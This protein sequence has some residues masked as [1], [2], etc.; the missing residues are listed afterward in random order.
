MRYALLACMLQ[1]CAFYVSHAFLFV[2]LR[3]H[4]L[5][6]CVGFVTHMISNNPPGIQRSFAV[7]CDVFAVMSN[8]LTMHS[9]KERSE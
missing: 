6:S 1:V 4:V 8:S 7:S 2:M 5:V 9:K 3:L